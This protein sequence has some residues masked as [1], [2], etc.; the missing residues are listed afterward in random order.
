MSGLATAPGRRPPQPG[1]PAPHGHSR[2]AAAAAFPALLVSALLMVSCVGGGPVREAALAPGPLAPAELARTGTGAAEPVRN[3]PGRTGRAPEA[4]GLSTEGVPHTPEAARPDAAIAGRGSAGAAGGASGH[5]H[6]SL[7]PVANGDADD[8]LDHWGRRRLGRVSGLLSGAQDPDEDAAAFRGLLDTARNADAHPAPELHDEDTVT[9]LGHRRGVAYGRWTGGPADTLSIEFNL[10]HATGGMRDDRAFRAMLERAGKVWSRRIDDSW[11]AWERRYGES[12]GRPI[13]NYGVSGRD[14]RVGPGGE[15]STGVEIFITGAELTGNTAGLAGTRSLYPGDAW[16]PHTGAIA[17]DRDY[18]EEADGAGLFGTMVHEIGHVL[19]A[20]QGGEYMDRYA[21]W[22]DYHDG[23]WTGPHVVAVHGGP[24]PF[25]DSDDG[26]GWH[27]GE[28]NPDAGRFDFGHSGVCASVMA[29]CAHGAALPA[30]L[31]AEIDYAFLADI[32]LAVLPETDRPETYGLAGWMEH[33]AFTLSVSRA[34]EVSLADPQ[35]RYYDHGGSWQAL[36]TVDL[37]WAEADAFGTPSAGSPARTFPLGG[38]VRYAGGLLGAATGL[39]GMPPVFG[40]ASLSLDLDT[41]TGRASFTSLRLSQWGGLRMFGGGSLHYPVALADDGLRHEAPGISLAAGFHGPRHEEVA[42]ILDDARAGLVASFGAKHDERPARSDILAGAGHVRG[43]M[44]RGG[45]SGD[46][47]GWHRYECGSGPDCRGRF[48]W[49][50][51][52][53]EWRDVNATDDRSAR[54]R[55]LGWT[56]G[57]GEWISGDPFADHGA[58]R[59]SRRHA[60]ATDGRRGRYQRDGYYGVMEHAAFGTGFYAYSGWET[61]D[62][63]LWDFFIRG[64]GFQGDV[65]GSRP[66]GN[67]TWQGRMVGYQS[68]PGAGEDPFVQGGATVRLSLGR[69]RVDIGFS[70]VTGMDSGRPL[71][72]FGFDNIPLAADGAFDGFDGGPVEGAFFGPAHEEA[73]GMFHKNDNNVTGSFGA[74]AP[75][76]G[77]N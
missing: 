12:K 19:G 75:A 76:P 66:Q 33:A 61:P 45:W 62:G 74:V 31:P 16:E 49:W 67:A 3:T 36:E 51:P 35:P 29:Y 56:A 43:M 72:D 54:E 64:T 77:R 71:E 60:G 13:G 69:D 9:V 27:D 41:L 47:D 17:F 6:V 8:L 24:A 53:S 58:I 30:F 48:E 40:D 50:K 38:T 52:D 5:L 73:A 42:G 39:A 11:T 68:G 65:S 23:T 28:R 1:P 4:D 15:T 18:L 14:I 32:G 57:W 26:H 34:L 7:R 70:G 25:Q 46:A 10:E 44:Y 59:L 63:A 21:P 37:L 22:T 20:W 55:V 2:S